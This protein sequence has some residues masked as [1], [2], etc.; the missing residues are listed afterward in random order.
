MDILLRWAVGCP[1]TI[2]P[3]K[4]ESAKREWVYSGRYSIHM[5]LALRHL[6]LA[7]VAA[8]LVKL[9]LPPLLWGPLVERIDL[10]EDLCELLWVEMN[11]NC[12]SLAEGI[13]T[14][15]ELSLFFE[16]WSNRN[17]SSI[18]A[19]LASLHRTVLRALHQ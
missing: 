7:Y 16:R 5:P 10:D 9:G 18:T 3:T 13:D 14:D 4:W 17:A 8:E 12:G 19:H 1:T 2:F 15:A 11:L 6:C